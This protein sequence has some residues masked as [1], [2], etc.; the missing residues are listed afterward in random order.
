[1]NKYE[2]LKQMYINNKLESEFGGE[3][4]KFENQEQL[5]AELK[6]T[7]KR[8]VQIDEL[9]E[10]AWFASEKNDASEEEEKSCGCCEHKNEQKDAQ[11]TDE[12]S[13]EELIKKLEDKLGMEIHIFKV[14]PQEEFRRKMQEFEEIQRR[15]AADWLKVHPYPRYTL[16]DF[17]RD[18]IR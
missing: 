1:M 14:N 15:Q 8:I 2:F 16:F 10:Q 13:T 18:F 6:E 3:K 11:G 5:L 7:Y 17:M 9:E 12:E 4:F